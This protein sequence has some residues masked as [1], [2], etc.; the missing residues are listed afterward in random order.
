[1]MQV[2]NFHIFVEGRVQGVGFR[3]YTYKKARARG[4][5]GWVRNLLDGRVEIQVT[6]PSEELEG[7]LKDVERGPAFAKVKNLVSTASSIVASQDFMVEADEEMKT[8]GD[9]K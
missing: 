5:K 3:Q 1:M 7:F 8:E 2:K 9:Q 4:L 6:G